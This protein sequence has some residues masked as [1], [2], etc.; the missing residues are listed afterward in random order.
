M[1]PRRKPTSTRQKKADIQLKRAIKRGDI[2]PPDPKKNT[3]RKSHRVGPTGSVIG[4]AANPGNAAAVESSK[5]LQSAFIK[6][7][8]HFLETTKSLASTVGLPRPIPIEAAISADFAK[9]T[10]D[11]A[12]SCP[13]RPKWRFDMTKIE[14]EHNEEG[15]FKKWLLQT[16]E[17]VEKWQ[18]QDDATDIQESEGAAESLEPVI[19]IPRAPTH[20]ERNLEVWRQL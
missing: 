15:L 19:K 20:F 12:L 9:D 2:P 3:K 1:P 18:S 13:R 7:P 8:A 14:V 4:S 11:S 10:A 5:K 6:L 16:D 17:L